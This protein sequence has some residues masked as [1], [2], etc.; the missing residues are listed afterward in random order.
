MH[1]GADGAVAGDD[2]AVVQERGAPVRVPE[3][4][5]EVRV[6]ADRRAVAVDGGPAREAVLVAQRNGR[7]VVLPGI[8]RMRPSGDQAGAPGIDSPVSAS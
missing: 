8:S 5:V 7:V 1:P 6:A 4:P 3:D 2:E